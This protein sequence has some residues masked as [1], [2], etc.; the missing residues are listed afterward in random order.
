MLSNRLNRLV[1]HYCYVKSSKLI[2]IRTKAPSKDTIFVS[3]NKKKDSHCYDAENV[4]KVPGL[5]YI[6]FPKDISKY[7]MF[8]EKMVYLMI[9]YAICLDSLSVVYHFTEIDTRTNFHAS[10]RTRISVLNTYCFY[11][12]LMSTWIFHSFG[13][14]C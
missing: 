5:D 10:Q 2:D 14:Q 1:Y 8:L 7:Y 9:E 6:Y 3:S 11:K 13:K 12:F 4:Y